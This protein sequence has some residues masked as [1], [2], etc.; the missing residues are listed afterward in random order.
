MEQK[1]VAN[2]RKINKIKDEI[3]EAQVECNKEIEAASLKREKKHKK[4]NEQLL[5]LELETN[6]MLDELNKAK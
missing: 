2:Q 4:L 5:A 6:A 1:I 3:I